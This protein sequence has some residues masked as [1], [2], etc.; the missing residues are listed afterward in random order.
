LNENIAVSTNRFDFLKC[1]AA[2][3]GGD[4]P[5]ELLAGVSSFGFGGVNA[6][7]VLGAVPPALHSRRHP[8]AQSRA[9]SGPF[10][11]PLSAKSREALMVRARQLRHYLRAAKPHAEP[12]IASSRASA[13]DAIDAVLSH[14]GLSLD[15]APSVS[16]PIEIEPFELELICRALGEGLQADIHP[17]GLRDCVTIAELRER[18]SHL[19][20]SETGGDDTAA[21][22]S[23]DASHQTPRTALDPARL[24]QA[25]S[26]SE[27]LAALSLTLTEGRD[28]LPERL[29]ILASS[30][31]A[32]VGALDSFLASGTADPARAI[33]L[34]KARNARRQ[35]E[36]GGSSLKPSRA[37]HTLA[38]SP[39]AEIAG[40]WVSDRRTKLDWS[41][42]HG[43][44]TKP[45]RLSLPT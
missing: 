38:A 1:E 13:T 41:A 2:I 19:L 43:S 7:V 35:S 34:G 42:L 11:F 17:S 28:A 20:A 45:A 33:F 12:D 3:D 29:A 14:H 40:R 18:M 16:R 31:D 36:S 22:R 15:H 6:H 8:Q 32:L 5:G 24:P 30:P 4:K 39:L 37:P 23:R 44:D 21:S 9:F 27:W 10:L 26:G 25:G